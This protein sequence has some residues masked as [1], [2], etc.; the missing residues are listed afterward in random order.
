MNEEE[1]ILLDYMSENPETLTGVQILTNPA[2]WIMAKTT[3]DNVK[4]TLLYYYVKD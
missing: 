1:S 2:R 3:D 4:C